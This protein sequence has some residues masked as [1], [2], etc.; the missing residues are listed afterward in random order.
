[1]DALKTTPCKRPD[2]SLVRDPEPAFF[3]NGY[4]VMGWK[5]QDD[6]Y[7]QII[8]PSGKEKWRTLRQSNEN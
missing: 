2:F 3:T 7:F 1:M 6:L 5:Y 4:T 8:W